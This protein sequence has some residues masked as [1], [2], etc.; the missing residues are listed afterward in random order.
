MKDLADALLCTVYEPTPGNRETT[1]LLRYTHS[2]E[3]IVITSD[4][5]RENIAISMVENNN[6]R[7]FHISHKMARIIYEPH[8]IE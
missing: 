8:I 6:N 4:T 7:L 3:I 5:I 1:Q 2:F